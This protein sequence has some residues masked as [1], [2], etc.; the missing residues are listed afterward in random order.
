MRYRFANCSLDT[1]RHAF[2]RSGAVVHVEPQVFDLLRVLAQAQGALVTR[3]DLIAQVWAGL[4]VSDATISARINAA[5]RAAGDD[6]KE[7]AIIATVARRGFR[8]A[9]KVENEAVPASLPDASRVASARPTLAVLAFEYLSPDLD[10]ML[11]DGIVDEIT[12]ALS[13][14]QEFSVIARQSAF[15]LRDRKP[16]IASAAA[17][18]GADYLVEGTV[19]RSGERLRIGVNLV[20]ATGR[21]LWSARYDDKLD[22]LF[23]LQDRIAAQVAGQLPVNLRS[24]E[25][26]RIGNGAAPT[27]P[28]RALVLRALPHLWIHKRDENAQAIALLTRAL[29]LNPDHVPALAY[30]AW[31][32]AQKP[33]YLWS[34][35]PATDRAEALSLAHRAAERVGDD[36]PS[37]VAISAAYSMALAD[38]APA[39]S[40][41]RRA[42]KLDPNNAWG[43]LRLGWALIYAEKPEAALVE[44]GHARR[45][46]PLDPFLFN[47]EQGSAAAL[48]DMG[49]QEEALALA[50][51]VLVNWPDKDW[52]YRWLTSFYGTIGDTEKAAWAANRLFETH[53]GLTLEAVIASVPPATASKYPGYVAG[54]RRALE[55]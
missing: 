11:A 29:D 14:V 18:L 54:L 8:L 37:L 46:S 28:V 25:I 50:L 12:A 23:D 34:D 41:A 9:A 33:S 55:R 43:R 2:E 39:L 31:A 4:N 6:G 10:D 48:R 5:R 22:D 7:Q 52:I 15:A 1:D 44:F 27:D 42:L 24:A 20:D 45:L 36:P 3:D 19:N 26:S 53:P 49:R 30:K 51:H 47:I 16:D 17:I 40:F 32:L 13:R 35:D 21:S 38:T